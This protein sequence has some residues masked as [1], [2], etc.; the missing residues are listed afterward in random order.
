MKKIKVGVT[1]P[2]D[3][4]NKIFTEERGFHPP[5][6]LHP[7]M[8]TLPT[9]DLVVFSGGDDVNPA[10]YGQQRHRT[11]TFVNKTR[12]D[13]ELKV[14]SAY[15]DK[16]KIGVCRGAQLL[17]IANGGS[18]WQDSDGHHMTHMVW[19]IVRNKAEEVTSVHHQICRLTKKMQLLAY[20]METKCNNFWDDKGIYKM[21]KEEEEVEAF[22]I[23]HDKA[24]CVQWHPEYG[25]KNSEDYFWLLFEDYLRIYLEPELKN[26]VHVG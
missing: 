10:L 26:I 19:D 17:C 11:V 20:G 21:P 5:V 7:S 13:F 8:T 25:H 1:C 18:L 23:E 3:G 2:T 4:L 15:W 24:L 9:L 16:P 12:D 14:H 6:L 22:F